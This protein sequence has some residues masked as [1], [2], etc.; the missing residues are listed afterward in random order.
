MHSLPN[1]LGKQEIVN[2]NK[3]SRP[4]HKSGQQTLTPHILTAF[5]YKMIE[6]AS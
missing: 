5:P 2:K 4:V 6:K 1:C 3:A